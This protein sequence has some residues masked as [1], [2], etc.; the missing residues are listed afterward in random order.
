[1]ATR[2][3]G[4]PAPK[5]APPPAPA[6][7][8]QPDPFDK[9]QDRGEIPPP[10][11]APV[12]TTS[13][14]SR[15]APAVSTPPAPPKPISPEPKPAPVRPKPAAPKPAEPAPASQPAPAARAGFRG[16][17]VAAAGQ[18]V[19]RGFVAVFRRTHEGA[20]A[21][22]E[23]P[24]RPDGSYEVPADPTDRVELVG[25]RGPDGKELKFQSGPSRRAQA[26]VGQWD[27][28]LTE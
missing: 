21:T 9:V 17:I 3:G 18:P 27:I 20:T 11:Q 28:R 13:A 22:L 10:A 23:A 5:P 24:T 19:G 1:M 4:E 7:E 6:V 14:P 26:V 15:P 12:P 25:I 16:T 2:G 8:V